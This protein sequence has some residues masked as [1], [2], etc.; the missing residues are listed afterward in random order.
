MSELVGL[1]AVGG[2]AVAAGMLLE[3]NNSSKNVI[4]KGLSSLSVDITRRKRRPRRRR[5]T[6]TRRTRTRRTRTRRTR[7]TRRS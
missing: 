6:V 3:G 7:R 5:A 2:L 4:K 1:A